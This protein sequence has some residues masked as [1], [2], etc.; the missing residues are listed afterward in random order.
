MGDIKWAKWRKDP[1]PENLPDCQM[2]YRALIADRRTQMFYYLNVKGTSVAV[3]K[4]AMEQQM[5]IGEQSEQFRRCCSGTGQA[6]IRH[7]FHGCFRIFSLVVN[8]L[9][10]VGRFADGDNVHAPVG[11]G[12]SHLADKGRAA[13]GSYSII[14]REHNAERLFLVDHRPYHAL[15]SWFK[16]VQRQ[17]HPG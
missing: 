1:R 12:A 10:T 9:N 15:V 7:Q 13:H 3:F 2:F 6:I 5:A 14:A 17:S 11:V 8:C 16:N 4:A